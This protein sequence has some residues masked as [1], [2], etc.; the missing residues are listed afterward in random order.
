[1]Q[2][3]P[4]THEPGDM[5]RAMECEELVRPFVKSIV[6]TAIASGWACDE[7]L[8]AFEEAVKDIRTGEPITQ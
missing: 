6:A 2:I 3:P 5:Q 1:M 4:P 7:V 8:I